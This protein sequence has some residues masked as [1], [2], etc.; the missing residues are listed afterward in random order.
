MMQV[1]NDG[2]SQAI[3]HM[4]C[5]RVNGATPAQR[6]QQCQDI[7]ALF[8]A[9][10]GSVGGLQC[11]QVG[12]N[13]VE[14]ADAWDVLV[15]MVFDSQ[16]TLSA[17]MDSSAHQNIKCQVGP[18]RASRGQA[19]ILLSGCMSAEIEQAHEAAVSHV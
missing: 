4:V 7:V 16:L 19:D 5:W 13:T 11:M 14:H 12:C 8:E 15:Y 10:R 9:L 17:Y 3:G 1:T 6:R 18:M 2:D